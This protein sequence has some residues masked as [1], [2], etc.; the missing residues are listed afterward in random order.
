MIEDD[1]PLLPSVSLTS[2]RYIYSY[3]SKRE[4]VSFWWDLYLHENLLH[5][6]LTL[7]TETEANI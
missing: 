1:N 5:T 7:L 6:Y 2:I 4:K 3:K